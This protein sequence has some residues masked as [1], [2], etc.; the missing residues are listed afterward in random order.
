MNSNPQNA[1]KIDKNDK[2]LKRLERMF[3]SVKN[4]FTYNKYSKKIDRE[5]HK[6]VAQMSHML[7]ICNTQASDV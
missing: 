6:H 4:C 2:W 7:H 3:D 1:K 5:R